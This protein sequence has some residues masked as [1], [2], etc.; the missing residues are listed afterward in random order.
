MIDN[1]QKN[2][3]NSPFRFE[4]QQQEIIHDRL[5]RLISKGAADF[6]KDACKIMSGSIDP[7][8]ATT[9]HIVAHLLREIE[10]SLRSVL[11]PLYN[12]PESQN[13]EKVLIAA[14]KSLPKS[15]G[16]IQEIDFILRSLNVSDEDTLAKAWKSLPG[17]DGLQ[18]YTHRR[19][20]NGARK[21]DDDFKDLFTR[22]ETIF[23][24]VLDKFE[25]Q[26]IEV[27][28]SVDVLLQ[29][30]NP[31]SDDAQYLCSSVPNSFTS[32]NYFFEK[33]TNPKWLP[34]LTKRGFF[35]DPPPIDYRDTPEGTA[36]IFTPWPSSI[37]LNKMSV[38][39]PEKVKNI[40]ND[41][42]E[43]NNPKVCSDL[44]EIASNLPK[45][46]LSDLFDKIKS[47]ISISEQSDYIVYNASLVIKKFLEYNEM[48]AVISLT[49]TLLEVHSVGRESYKV[50]DQTY[51]PPPDVKG[52]FDDW[53]YGR[54][55]REDFKNISKMYPKE[56]LLVACSLLNDF[57]TIS[58]PDHVSGERQYIDY[59]YIER[60]AIEDNPQ[61]R[62]WN[63]EGLCYFLVDAVRDTADA[64]ISV[65]PHLLKEIVFLLENKKWSVFIRL[66][67]YLISQAESPDS[68]IL[69]HF[70]LNE[71]LFDSTDVNHEYFL[72]LTKHFSLLDF[73][74]QKIIYGWI[75]KGPERKDISPE[76]KEYWQLKKLKQIENHL[77]SPW[78]EKLEEL[79]SK[80]NPPDRLDFES[81]IIEYPRSQS[82]FKAQQI[83]EMDTSEIKKLIINWK[84]DSINT[85]VE[86]SQHDFT[87]QIAESIRLKPDLFLSMWK[88]FKEVRSIYILTYVRT[89]N[90][91]LRGGYLLGW[92]T[93]IEFLQWAVSQ[94]EETDQN[95]DWRSIKSSAGSILETGI[96]ER[97]IP[98]KLRSSVWNIINKLVQKSHSTDDHQNITQE[99]FD[100]DYYS[101]AINT[102]SGY[103]IQVAIEYGLW[104]KE[105]EKSAGFDSIS[106]L[107]NVLEEALKDP[108]A[109]VI[110]IFGRY[111]PWLFFLDKNWLQLNITKIFPTGQLSQKIYYAAWNS[112]LLWSSFQI[113]IFI[114]LLDYYQKHVDSLPGNQSNSIV[115]SLEQKM[116]EHIVIMY[117]WKY[118]ELQ[119]KLFVDFWVKASDS[120]RGYTIEFIGRVLRKDESGSRE[121]I[122]RLVQMWNYR[123]SV[124]ESALDKTVFHEEISNFSW[125]FVSGQFEKTWI[126]NQFLYSLNYGSKVRAHT[127][128]ADQ[129][130]EKVDENPLEV[131]DILV[132]I[133]DQKESNWM[134]L[135]SKNDIFT[136]LRKTLNHSDTNINQKV[137]GLIS[138]LLARGYS[139]YNALRS[140]F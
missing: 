118:V 31:T 132:K 17:N 116:A 30:D 74:D 85:F 140:E 64:I 79:L 26:Y 57:V 139:E 60:P 36:I 43:T 92:E 127:M 105:T 65:N 28:N 108:S 103:A 20:L 133:L 76:K 88:D 97:T 47:W 99:D 32:Y 91:L 10:S 134:I 70:L 78:K 58:Y 42:S 136:I 100:K 75:D 68:D 4:N 82:P 54:F 55:M 77:V 115:V 59:T 23:S 119:D 6:Y 62:P 117:L 19:N 122:E 41:I 35:R 125:W 87:Y 24:S 9:T 90:E 95:N 51:T 25:T 80:H 129:L 29:K 106:E 40:L 101:Y 104:I 53:H 14:C 21:L 15:G 34:M 121:Y 52:R 81:Y 102:L 22:M 89:F 138:K 38:I 98:Y 7:V 46:E 130:V 63:S 11:I 110:S 107:K 137:K 96:K 72:L 94:T 109:Q 112:Y 124:V 56:S 33:L 73:E 27:F 67:M 69:A 126:L 5:S 45:N 48:D 114:L 49:K 128:I 71:K 44:L 123:V 135:G 16:H 3:P 1:L 84:P 113:D 8:L 2:I 66:S 83:V 50:G 131:L 39:E 13:D 86:E 111:L 37:Y 120:L 18:M 93:I 12:Y 61:N